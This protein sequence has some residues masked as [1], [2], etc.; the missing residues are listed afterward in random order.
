M[1]Y[2]EKYFVAAGIYTGP[3]KNP[4]SH[5]ITV[6]NR[7]TVDSTKIDGICM[8]LWYTA[9][10][11]VMSRCDFESYY[12]IIFEEV[13]AEKR[14]SFKEVVDDMVDWGVLQWAEDENLDTAMTMAAAKLNLFPLAWETRKQL[15]K[16]FSLRVKD[17]CRLLFLKKVLTAE[18]YSFYLYIKNNPE[19]DIMKFADENCVDGLYGDSNCNLGELANSLMRKGYLIPIGWTNPYY[20]DKEIIEY[21][22]A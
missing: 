6:Y 11:K 2:K 8:A 4:D 16:K 20:G 19:Y 7:R 5:G 15:K 22:D 17:I 21:E 1:D 13:P 12:K 14:P 10:G 3:C 9:L 18:E